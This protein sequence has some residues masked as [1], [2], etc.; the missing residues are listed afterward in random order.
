[1][2]SKRILQIILAILGIVPLVTGIWGMLPPGVND[3]TF[4]IVISASNA[5]HTMLDSTFRFYSGIWFGLGFF[6]IYIIPSI[7]KHQFSL[8][9]IS[10]MIFLGGIGR[11]LS[12]FTL[13]A[14]PFIFITFTVLE[15]LFPLLLLLQNRVVKGTS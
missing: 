12:I 11:L 15:L 13:A 6:M 1:M 8:R 4:D 2:K 7:E 10:I 3:K 5:G 9:I 14:P